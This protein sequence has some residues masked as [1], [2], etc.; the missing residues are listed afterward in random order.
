LQSAKKYFN[1]LFRRIDI[2]PL[3]RSGS[4][5]R[6]VIFLTWAVN[7]LIF[8][9]IDFLPLDDYAAH[10]SQYEISKYTIELSSA[11]IQP[12]IIIAFYSASF[13]IVTSYDVNPFKFE[14]KPVEHDRS[15]PL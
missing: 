3:N 9:T 11:D 5:F 12:D 13:G 4:A 6:T 2:S 14:I 15:P 8:L 7:A 1:N 10:S